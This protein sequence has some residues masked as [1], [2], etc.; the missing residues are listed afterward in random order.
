[1]TDLHTHILP[2]MDDGSPDV[3]TSI[4]MLRMEAAQGVHTVVLTPHFYRNRERPEHF[5]ERR[6]QSAVQLAK[7]LRALPDGERDKLPR[8]LVGAEVA[9]VPN[10][11]DL[12]DLAEFRIG[13]SGY[14]L[15]ELPFSP[16]DD[17]MIH[18]IYGLMGRTGLTPVIAHL[19]RYI[20]GQKAEHIEEVFSLGVPIQ[21]SADVLLQPFSKG[22][23]LLRQGRAHLVA[24][25]C[26]NIGRRPPNLGPAMA[27]VAK[28][29][30]SDRRAALDR[31]ADK[32]LAAPG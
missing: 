31:R 17:S 14:F 3:E 10:L 7:G 32:L 11:P 18:Q 5:L 1:M 27:A 15:L 23:K 21:V 19:E 8:I 9:W 28:K 4:T 26:H 30:G 29:L 25:D 22:M 24:S 16:W 6:Y 13:E 12:V 2:G 20:K